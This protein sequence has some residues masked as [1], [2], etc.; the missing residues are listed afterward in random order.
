MSTA[1]VSTA[2][3]STEQKAV[4]HVVAIMPSPLISN[5]R[6]DSRLA[7]TVPS[8]IMVAGA[9]GEVGRSLVAH[10]SASGVEHISALVRNPKTGVAAELGCMKGVHCSE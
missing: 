3:V 10:L 6:K 9:T 8:H 5:V 4:E 2:A 1:A 7:T